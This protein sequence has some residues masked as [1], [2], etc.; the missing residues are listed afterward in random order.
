MY[1]SLLT[2]ESMK[3]T[4]LY[5]FST[6]GDGWKSEWNSSMSTESRQISSAMAFDTWYRQRHS[7]ITIYSLFYISLSIV[8]LVEHSVSSTW[9]A[10]CSETI[11]IFF[12]IS[13]MRRLSWFRTNSKR[14]IRYSLSSRE[15]TLITVKDDQRYILVLTKLM[16]VHN[17]I[18]ISSK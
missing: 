14:S 12:L 1:E 16:N 18:Q 5:I 2:E 8:V 9:S 15:A 6:W 7:S 4:D 13:S 17:G 11:L 3:L 10:T